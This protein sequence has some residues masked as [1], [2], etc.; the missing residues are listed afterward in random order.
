MMEFVV[1]LQVE[2]EMQ[3]KQVL[4]RLNQALIIS[5]IG[6]GRIILLIKDIYNDFKNRLKEARGLAISEGISSNTFRKAK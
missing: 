5:K 1:D 4:S 3:L 6:K 2:D